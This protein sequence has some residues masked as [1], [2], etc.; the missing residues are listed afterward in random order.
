MRARRGLTLFEAVVALAIVGLT[1]IGA[2][3]AV[4]A[5]MRTAERAR[6]AHIVSA[7]AVER[8]AFMYLMS[9]R[10]LLNL[11]D[12]IASGTFDYPMDEY[13][14]TATS[15][16]SS[17]YEG[18]YDTSVTILW[19]NGTQTESYETHGAQ[20]RTPATINAAARR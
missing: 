16:P 11:P 9:D 2:L 10:D 1:A 4:G 3:E 15:K 12:S 13:Q 7:L 5:E 18:L 8:T 6:R 14:W 17:D 20:Y 19:K